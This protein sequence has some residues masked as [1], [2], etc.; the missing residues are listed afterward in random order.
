[1]LPP[2]PRKFADADSSRVQERQH[3]RVTFGFRR[4]DKS[5]NLLLVQDSVGERVADGG[6]LQRPRLVVR[7]SPQTMAEG[8]QRLDGSQR[9]SSRRRLK[10]SSFERVGKRLKLG[11]RHL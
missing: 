6:Q 11:K 10:P 4:S 1:M 3:H 2:N 7:Q 8:V 9:P 5:L